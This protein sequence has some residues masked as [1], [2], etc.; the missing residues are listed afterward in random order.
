MPRFRFEIIGEVVA[1]D[2][3]KAEEKIY[4]GVGLENIE[5]NEGPDVVMEEDDEEDEDRVGP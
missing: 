1:E 5:F 2:E 4:A 3:S